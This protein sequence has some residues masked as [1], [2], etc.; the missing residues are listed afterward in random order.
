MA[1]A[2]WS[3]GPRGQSAPPLIQLGKADP[4]EAQ[5]AIEQV[6][7]Q[8][9]TGNYFLE[10]NLRVMPRRGEERSVPGRLWGSRNEQGALSRVAVTLTEGGSGA[11]ERRLL[12][13]SGRESAVWRW[14]TG[15]NVEQLGPA[16]PFD[17]VVPS[18]QL[19]AFDLQMPFV[20]WEKFD[21]QG[22]TRF[23]G[24]PAHIMIMRPPTPFTA[25]YP[26]VTGV[27]VYLDTQFNAL[28]QTELLGARNAILKTVSLV[29][30]KRIGEQWIPKTFDVR[31]DRTRDKTRLEV[32][33]A[34]LNLDF[35]RAL[36]EPAQLVDDVR[37][38]AESQLTRIAP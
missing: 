20:Y 10:F 11:V 12:I 22:L 21:Y 25:K 24:R 8:G 29:D 32:T 27:R 14:D 33:A 5:A 38:P 7:R 6:R 2:A 34:G 37:A 1:S 19:T 26:E 9:I 35:S 36:F 3:A 17:P 30:L 13:Q 4:A 18:T 23:K 16:S 31:D 15:G 28:V